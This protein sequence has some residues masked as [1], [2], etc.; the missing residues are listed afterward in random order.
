MLNNGFQRLAECHALLCDDAGRVKRYEAIVKA[1]VD[2]FFGTVQ[3]VT[4]KDRVCYKWA[5]VDENPMRHI[6]DVGHGSEDITGLYRAYLGGC[7]GITAA[8]M[9]CPLVSRLDVV[10]LGKTADG[11]EAFMDRAALVIEPCSMI[12]SSRTTRP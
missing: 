2:W 3:R 6:E 7:Y 5:Y 10:S 1:S 9:G 8:T 4:V 11:I 12:L